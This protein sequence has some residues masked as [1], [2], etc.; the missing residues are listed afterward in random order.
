MYKFNL[1]F[2]YFSV[3]RIPMKGYG[4]W[5]LL[6]EKKSGYKPLSQLRHQLTHL[7]PFITNL[8]SKLDLSVHKFHQKVTRLNFLLY[9][10]HLFIS[11]RIFLLTVYSSSFR[12]YNRLNILTLY[13]CILVYLINLIL[14]KKL[15]ILVWESKG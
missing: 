9:D 2:N 15:R 14:V 1:D 5:I 11:F 3:Y 4:L 13:N 6:L 10:F 12:I 8:T 7:T